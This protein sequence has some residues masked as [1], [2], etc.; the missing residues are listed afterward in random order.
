VP[1]TVLCIQPCR[2]LLLH[3]KRR[4]IGTPARALPPRLL[5]LLPVLFVPIALCR[6]ISSS[7]ECWTTELPA[8]ACRCLHSA[9]QVPDRI[10]V[11]KSPCVILLT[12][13]KR[14]CHLLLLTGLHMLAHV[15][16]LQVPFKACRKPLLLLLLPPLPVRVLRG[17]AL[18]LLP[19]LRLHC[20]LRL[21][22][23]LLLLLL[24]KPL[25]RRRLYVLHSLLQSLLHPAM[26]LHSL[27]RPTMLL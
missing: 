26:L 14:R 20:R 13:S 10:V 5:L 1:S 15:S 9:V 11:S 8:A 6:R 7:I 21:P 22:R 12:Y 2:L 17:L 19:L 23:V 16:L 18:Q 27:L 24:A 4:T 25:R 3:T